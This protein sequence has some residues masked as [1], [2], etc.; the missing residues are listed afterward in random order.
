MRF[1][2]GLAVG[3]AYTGGARHNVG[4]EGSLSGVG[5]VTGP[6]QV[7]TT[8]PTP[9]DIDLPGDDVGVHPPGSVTNSEDSA[10]DRPQGSNDGFR[11]ESPM[12][13]N[14]EF[15]EIP[16]PDSSDQGDDMYR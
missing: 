15:P 9:M 7:D 1:H 8:E 2:W 14:E 3:H 12:S 5:L 10:Y 6:Q 16:E 13:D 4:G 11:F